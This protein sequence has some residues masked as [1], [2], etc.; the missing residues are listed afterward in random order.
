MIEKEKQT[1]KSRYNRDWERGI[2][3][4]FLK[5]GYPHIMHFT[6]IFTYNL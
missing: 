4:G 6:G 5:W 3:G 1:N 2:Y